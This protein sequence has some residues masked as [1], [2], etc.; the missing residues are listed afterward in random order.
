MNSNLE[1]IRRPVESSLREFD[2]F[3]R[4]A[5]S[6]EEDDILKGMVDYI[7]SSRGKGLRPTIVMLVAAGI[8][9]EHAVGKRAMLAAMLVEMIHLASLVHD[10]VIDESDLRRGRPSAKAVWQSHNAVVLGDYILAKNMM[11][12]LGSGQYDL[13]SHIIGHMAQLCEGEILQSNH[14]KSFDTD[15]NA[16]YD[17]IYRKTACLF[18]AASSAGAMSVGADREL[19]D[20]MFKFGE[21][22]GMA[23][24][25]A[26]DILDYVGDAHTGKPTM[27]D[28]REGKITLPL[29]EAMEQM[30][31]DERCQTIDCL[32]QCP[33]SDDMTSRIVE[34]VIA[35]DGISRARETMKAFLQRALST[36]AHLEDSR[37]RNSL[38]ELCAFV[39]ERN[40]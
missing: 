30:G 27:E 12:G 19:R 9:G 6:V 38:A 10:D 26:D 1:S 7:L 13:V 11:V 15:R 39:A 17:I 5:F 25:I 24:Q 36:L 40:S 2:D 14:Q 20:E 4:N 33:T 35:Y 37:F 34:K 21:N 28:V 3:V 32:R 18:A 16:Y 22:F 8:K 23:F 29:I 31:E